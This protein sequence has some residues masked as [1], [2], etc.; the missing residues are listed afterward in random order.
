MTPENFLL[1][2]V[3]F[4]VASVALG[5]LAYAFVLNRRGSEP[6]EEDEETQQAPGATPAPAPQPAPVAHPTTPEPMLPPPADLDRPGFRTL[7][8]IHQDDASGRVFVRIGDREYRKPE[9]IHSAADQAS[10]AQVISSLEG[11]LRAAKMPPE[12]LEAPP[13]VYAET[14]SRPLSMVE[15]IN[16]IVSR[17]LEGVTGIY[18]AVRLVEGPEGAVRVY[19]GVDRYDAVEDV[20]DPEIRRII[21]EA[22]AEWESRS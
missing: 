3:V 19:V 7:L 2:G 22:V 20:P 18:R 16:A 17:R 6:A 9:D 1:F 15:Q 10:I 8:T 4:I 5:L 12:K 13:E 11:L 21:R 14:P